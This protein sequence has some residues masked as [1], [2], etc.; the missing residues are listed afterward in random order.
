MLGHPRFQDRTG[1]AS[2]RSVET[3]A[4]ST[5]RRSP[6]RLAGRHN[7]PV[8]KANGA[9]LSHRTAYPN[10][11]DGGAGKLSGLWG[12]A[13]R[14]NHW[15]GDLAGRR[16]GKMISKLKR[17]RTKRSEERQEGKESV[18]KCRIRWSR[19]YYKQKTSKK[20]HI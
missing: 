10:A 18:R 6:R 13:Q 7:D 11:L 9:L 1:R 12:G 17:R 5:G 2:H 20:T 4:H 16:F 8:A 14:I 3:P 15:R 19:K